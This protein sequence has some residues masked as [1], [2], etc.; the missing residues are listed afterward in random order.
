MA[1]EQIWDRAPLSHFI[2]IKDE[3]ISFGRY[4]NP[5]NLQIYSDILKNISGNF[6][7]KKPL[8]EN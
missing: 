6:D 4:I 8:N 1:M 2:P 3:N 7:Q 5:L